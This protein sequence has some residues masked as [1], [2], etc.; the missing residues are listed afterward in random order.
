MTYKPEKA[1]T[2]NASNHV[3]N[4]SLAEKSK[5]AKEQEA[6]IVCL[7]FCPDFL[8]DALKRFNEISD[9]ISYEDRGRIFLTTPKAWK[10]DLREKKKNSIA[11]LFHDKSYLREFVD[12]FKEI[13]EGPLRDRLLNKNI[14]FM[15]THRLDKELEERIKKILKG[16]EVSKPDE[17]SKEQYKNTIVLEDRTISQTKNN[18]LIDNILVSNIFRSHIEEMK[19]KSIDS[20]IG[21]GF[22]NLDSALDGGLRTKRLYAIGGITS[23]GKTTFVMNIADNVASSGHDVLV[24]SLEMSTSEMLM[25]NLARQIFLSNNNVEKNKRL[26]VKDLPTVRELCS[27]IYPNMNTCT[28]D[29]KLMDRVDQLKPLLNEAEETYARSTLGKHLSIYGMEL[30]AVKFDT[31]KRVLEEFAEANSKMP[32]LVVVD[33]LQIMASPKGNFNLS[34]KQIVDKNITE[35]KRIAVEFNIAVMVV[36]SFNRDSYHEKISLKSFKESGG[37]EYSCDVMM[38]LQL[39]GITWKDKE[40]AKE[41]PQEF[42]KKA[43]GDDL[44]K[45]E[46]VILKNRMYK[47]FEEVCFDYYVKSDYFM[48]KWNEKKN[49]SKKEPQLRKRESYTNF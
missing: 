5:E 35:L 30:G 40:N 21:T 9:K 33:Y 6:K 7:D 8:K 41:D 22:G 13:N 34:E 26:K 45:V 18:P 16:E 3:Q 32:R 11:I 14:P 25:K 47:V 42:N 12:R 31:I 23:V 27:A 39:G 24:F 46:L 38:G 43:M 4:Q 49:N 29:E 2:T 48:E 37:I 44:R 20:V 1:K 28:A 17:S 19:S 15:T 36:S 10:E